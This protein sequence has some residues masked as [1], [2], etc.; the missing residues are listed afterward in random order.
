MDPKNCANFIAD[1]FKVTKRYQLQLPYVQSCGVYIMPHHVMSYYTHTPYKNTTVVIVGKFG[2][3]ILFK[4]LV[5]KL[6]NK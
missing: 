2:K 6:M 5:K 3:F 4:H 1:A